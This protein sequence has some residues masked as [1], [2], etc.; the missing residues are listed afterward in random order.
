MNKILGLTKVFLK[1]SFS[2]Y[3]ETSKIKKQTISQ[4]ILK[5]LGIIILTV[6]LMSIFG[7]ISFTIID[8]L[9]Q[10]GQPAL[11]LGLALLSVAVLLL[12]QTLIT[13]INL[14]YFAKDIEYILPLPLKPYEIVIAKF[15]TL[16][17]TEYITVFMFML[18]P[19]VIYGILTGATALY[20]LYALLVLLVFPILPAIISCIIVMI[21]MC[22]SG[23]TKNKDKFQVIATIVMI[24]AV[25]FIQ[26]QFSGQNETT[27]EE[28]IQMLTQ[29]NGLVEQ[30]DDYFITLG[31]SIN[32]ITNYNNVNGFIS[33]IK[34]IG[35]TVIAYIIFILLSQKLYL[36]GAIGAGYSGKKKRTKNK[37]GLPYKKQ[38]IGLSY[39]KK[40]LIILFKNPIFF[41]QC[42]LP[43]ILIPII[44]IVS[45]IASAGGVEQMELEGMSDINASNTVGLCIIIAIN[46]FLYVMN[47]I[48]V[49]AISRDGENAVFMKYI[50][51]E[52]SKQCTYKIIPAVIMNIFTIAIIITLA[53]IL[54]KLTI[55]FII[56]SSIVSVLI[57]IFYSYLMIIVD[58]K[59]PKLKWD[60]EYAVVKQNLNMIFEFILSIAIIILLIP[61]AFVM[62]E[63]SCIITAML[64]IIVFI[65]GIYLVRKYIDKNQ[66]KLF[67]KIN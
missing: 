26:M 18:A 66:V 67:E 48:S 28:M 24:L 64:F 53:A 16:I 52:L 32:T 23:L 47:F 22:F 11:F 10:V 43:S 30:I 13:A 40:E 14:F 46:V 37:S 61:I 7:F 3:K 5:I 65:L 15:N 55:P 12:I 62:A 6:Y 41:T 20:Y 57:S 39:V 8:E 9:N 42:I 19:F 49:T 35:I 33:L 1:T 50:P 25:I 36:K 44:M 27:N 58:L 29:V 63:V 59:R 54:F 2:R 51:L 60:T 17:I 21:A 4:K 31:D 45:I 56:I 34:L 38:N